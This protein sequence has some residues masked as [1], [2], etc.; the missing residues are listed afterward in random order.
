M[1]YTIKSGFTLVELMVVIAIIGILA[2]ALFPQMN[3]YLA[4]SRD[5]A[6]IQTAHKLSSF[7]VM[8]GVDFGDFPPVVEANRS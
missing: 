3:Q 5:S 7:L 1:K 8:Y 6:R 2:A 4:R